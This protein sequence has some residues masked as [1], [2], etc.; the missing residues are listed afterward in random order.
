MIRLSTSMI[1]DAGTS[2][3]N[4]QA[5]A[6]LH[7][8]QQIAAGRRILK[9]SDDPVNAARALVVS[10]SRDV[11]NQYSA[12]QNNA[13]SALGLEDGYLAGVTDV[14]GRIQD[15]IVQ[16]QGPAMTAT[17]RAG[18]ATELRARFDELL[19]MAN[20]T[21][22]SG[23][24]MFAGYQGSGVPFQGSVNGI[25]A[26]GDIAY[27]GDAGQVRLQVSPGRD[28]ETGDPGSDVF[29]TKVAGANRSVFGI[30]ADLV[31][32][33][34]GP[35]TGAAYTTSLSQAM[36]NVR[37]ATDNVTRVRAAV[38]SRLG[39]LDSLATVNDNLDLTY[40]QTLSTIQDLDYTKAATE[41]SL[42]QTALQAAQKSFMSA[43]QLS[44][45]NYL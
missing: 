10:Q 23:Q 3:I 5:S 26:G 40:Q 9:P 45:F 1:Y 38:G 6:L 33:I 29:Y 42:R 18:L 17:T 21:D 15:L 30:V 43:T 25:I 22:G 37:S 2:G 8:Q 27:N 7:V 11:V 44:L 34:E 20:A 19:G 39:E 28:M 31:G 35:S 41:L 14:L 13:K 36:T 12:N 16:A 32:V 24:Y 4:A